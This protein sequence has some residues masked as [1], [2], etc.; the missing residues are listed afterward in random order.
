[1]LALLANTLP[2]KDRSAQAL[3]VTHRAVETALILEGER[4]EAETA[5][6]A[7]MSAAEE[8]AGAKLG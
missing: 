1:M 4:G 8:I 7:L 3:S 6:P 5:V 2:G